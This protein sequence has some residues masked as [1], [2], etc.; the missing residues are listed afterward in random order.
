[1]NAAARDDAGGFDV[2]GAA[3]G[4]FDRAF[5]V[6][7]GAQSVH[8]AS[9]QVHAD[10]RVDDVA[11]AFDGFAFVNVGVA[12]ENDRADAVGFQVQSHAFDAA[13]KFDQFAGLHLVQSVNARDAVADGQHLSDFGHIRF[14][15]EIFDALF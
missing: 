2:N 12:A 13:F 8:D 15:T 1:M 5:A 4:R 14:G 3:F 7:R 10:R 6:D 11:R 9:Q